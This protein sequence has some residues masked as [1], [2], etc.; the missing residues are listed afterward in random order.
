MGIKYDDKGAIKRPDKKIQF[1]TEMAQHLVA[2][3]KDPV[4]FAENFYY[5]IH[6]IEGSQ[7]IKLRNYQLKMLKAFVENR[8]VITNASRQIGKTTI[9]GIYLL[10]YVCF[11]KDKTVA[12]LANKADTAKGIL[13]E[14]KYAYERLPEY[15]KPGIKEYNAF[16]VEFDNGCK[17]ISRA[18]SAD[19]LRG[20]SV[21]IMF[22]DEFSFVPTNIADDFW[23]A[24][25]PTIS[26]GGSCILVSTPNGIGNLFYKIWKNAIDQKNS[27]YPI[28]ILWDEVPGRDEKWKQETIKDIGLIRFNQEFGCAFQGSTVTLI[29]SDYMIRKLKSEEPV[30][31]PDEYTKIWKRK[32]PGHKY[33]ISIDTAGGVGS[34]NSVM[35]IFDIT[36]Y[37]NEPAEQVAIYRNSM[38]PPYKFA[39]IVYDSLLYWN[40]A[41]IIGELN[42]LSAEVINRLFNDNEYEN[43]FY[44]YEDETMGIYSDKTSKP[45][46]CLMFKDELESDKML[47]RDSE[48]IDEIGYFEEPKPGIYKAKEGR[49]NHDDCVITCVWA[50]YFLKSQYF[51]DEKSTW[52]E[53]SENEEDFPENKENEEALQ[54]FLEQDKETHSEDWLENDEMNKYKTL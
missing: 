46:A 19:A 22:C 17:M 20:E 33:L 25:Y 21:S 45:K 15:L 53:N 13:G 41:Y 42:G 36:N 28:Q 49:N 27:F 26:T 12:I 40:N 5:I 54:A 29:D 35:N 8:K 4:Y 23:N 6:P 10:W 1:T 51:L 24:N 14:I 34:D 3:A 11:N 43:I 7:K 44:D 16:T 38:C 31:I 2:C 48:T 50:A 47:L 30:E 32:I 39:E 9:V 18:T 37:P 52:Y